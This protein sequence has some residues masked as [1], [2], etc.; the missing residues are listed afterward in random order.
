MID[1]QIA[2]VFLVVLWGIGIYGTG[3]IEKPLTFVVL[4]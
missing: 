1:Q 2:F 4:T 3:H